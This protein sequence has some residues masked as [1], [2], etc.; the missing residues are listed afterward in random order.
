MASGTR[1]APP[2]FRPGRAR[3]ASRIAGHQRLNYE[4]V[5]KQ[6]GLPYC[7]SC[8]KEV[9][10]GVRFCS[11]CG[12][13]VVQA[14]A[15]A[16]KGETPPA[17]PGPS[18]PSLTLP[19][20]LLALVVG[21]VFLFIGAL[22]LAIPFKS[23]VILAITL[24]ALFGVGVLSLTTVYGLSRRK[25]WLRKEG[26]ANAIAAIIVGVLFAASANALSLALGALGIVLGGGLLYYLRRPE[27]R[28]YLAE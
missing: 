23:E 17:P 28:Q 12:V 22:S 19:L 8:G 1:A 4:T 21:S 25:R 20:T 10:P 6:R 9:Q 26:W 5:P 16:F 24:V 13:P 18:K 27:S 2:G 11:N 7:S 14:Q 3:R 15:P